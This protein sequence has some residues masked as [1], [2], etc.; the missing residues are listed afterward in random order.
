MQG[1]ALTERQKQRIKQ[2]LSETDLSLENIAESVGCS[3]GAVRD[4]NRKNGIRDYGGNRSRWTVINSW[5]SQAE[6][7]QPTMETRSA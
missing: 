2:L 1:R 3:R 5:R 4:V 7:V 6:N